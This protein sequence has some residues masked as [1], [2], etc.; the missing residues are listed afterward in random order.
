MEIWNPK[1]PGTLWA[2][3][4]LLRDSFTFTMHEIV[5]FRAEDDRIILI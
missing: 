2:T 4:G 3:P 5:V 1:V